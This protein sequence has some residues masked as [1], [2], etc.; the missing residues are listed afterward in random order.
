MTLSSFRAA[1]RK[2]HLDQIKRVYGYLAKIRHAK[3]HFRIHQ[4]DYSTIPI[5]E[6][7]WTK[8]I[9]GEVKELLPNDTPPPMKN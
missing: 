7:N 5:P 3:L 2:G 4:P 6:H 9:Y 1:P 8:T